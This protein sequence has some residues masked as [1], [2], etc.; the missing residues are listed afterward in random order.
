MDDVRESRRLV[1][2]YSWDVEERI[3][4]ESDARPLGQTL[5]ED[6]GEYETLTAPWRK[7]FNPQ[8]LSKDNK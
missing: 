1:R 3:P 4:P 6:R 8:E 7:F 5:I 2:I